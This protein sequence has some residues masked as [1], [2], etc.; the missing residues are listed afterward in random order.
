MINW[1]EKA[2][3]ARVAKWTL[4][5][6]MVVA[7]SCFAMPAHA[8]DVYK[9][10]FST[11]VQPVHPKAVSF[12]KFAELV[13]ARTMGRVDITVFPSSQLGGEMETA[14]GL[15]LGSI[16]MGSITSSVLTSWVPEL[17]I[18][19]LPFLFRDDNH[20][21]KATAWL[22]DRLAPKFKTQGFRLLA[23]TINGARQ[24]M[25]TFP[26]R[27]PEDV[28]G[29]KMRVIQ[30][31]LHISLWR[32]LGANPVPIPAPEIYTSLQTKVVDFFDNTP[33]NYLTFKFYEVAPYYTNLSHA[34]AI[35]AW[36]VSERWFEKLPTADQKVVVDTAREIV[37]GI[38]KL[39]AEQ[40]KVSLAKTKELGATIISIDDKGPWQAKMAPI[41]EEYGKKIPGGAEMIKAIG[42]M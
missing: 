17:Q 28:A 3:L 4:W 21:A 18:I 22:A 10:K 23:F 40:D 30:S 13:K 5:T 11:D 31:P 35:A 33:T 37:P 14:E 26:I 20:A 9:G 25:S 8:A 27:K 12:V 32:Q 24:P 41:W 7:A 19:D 39:L 34:Y 42:A 2:L 16:E 29:K 15:R 1:L 36:V 6:L 38:H